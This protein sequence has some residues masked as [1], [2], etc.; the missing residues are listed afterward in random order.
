MKHWSRNLPG[1]IGKIIL[2]QA[3]AI[4]QLNKKIEFLNE[5][6]IS[7]QRDLDI[8]EFEILECVKSE[9]RPI[10]IKNARDFENDK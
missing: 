6:V 3:E 4:E 10:E 2:D 8:R 1:G 5:Q 7:C 9:W